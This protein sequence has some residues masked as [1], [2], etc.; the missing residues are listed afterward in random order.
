MY[1]GS[2]SSNSARFIRVTADGHM[3]QQANWWVSNVASIVWRWTKW[4]TFWICWYSTS[5]RTQI[6]RIRKKRLLHVQF[7]F[8]M[9]WYSKC[10][11]NLTFS[12]V[13][14]IVC[15]SRLGVWQQLDKYQVSQTEFMLRCSSLQINEKP[16]LI[17]FSGS[18]LLYSQRV[19]SCTLQ[20]TLQKETKT[21][22]RKKNIIEKV[23]KETQQRQSGCRAVGG[24]DISSLKRSETLIY[25]FSY[26]M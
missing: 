10:V 12:A 1:C 7:L 15:W 6:V 14:C 20:T 11:R 3:L 26:W 8:L 23:C 21:K 18:M 13:H 17:G 22:K 4:K 5:L 25:M 2:Y 24:N 9:P 19:K 16:R